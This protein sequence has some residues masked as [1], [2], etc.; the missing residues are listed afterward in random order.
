MAKKKKHTN[1]NEMCTYA[2]DAWESRTDSNVRERNDEKRIRLAENLCHKLHVHH[3]IQNICVRSKLWPF[4]LRNE[5]TR[6]KR[7]MYRYTKRYIHVTSREII[8]GRIQWDIGLCCF[9]MLVCVWI[10]LLGNV[11]ARQSVWWM[12]VCVYREMCTLPIYSHNR[13]I[14]HELKSKHN[15]TDSMRIFVENKNKV[16]NRM[17]NKRINTKYNKKWK[18]SFWIQGIIMCKRERELDVNWLWRWNEP[19]GFEHYAF[20][21]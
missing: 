17:R 18:F 19:R 3:I 8:H 4:E 20:N 5:K 1:T 13:T 7:W 6:A 9:R 14:R 16:H 12:C 2:A 11:Y 21:I 10:V 15:T